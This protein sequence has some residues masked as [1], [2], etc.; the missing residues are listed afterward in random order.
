MP[1]LKYYSILSLTIAMLTR[2]RARAGATAAI[3]RARPGIFSAPPRAST[4][5][6][7]RRS[8]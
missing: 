8:R 4:M 1:R 7:C 3:Q 5:T 2:P 6:A